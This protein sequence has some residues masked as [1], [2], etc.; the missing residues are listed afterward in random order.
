[1]SRCGCVLFA[2]ALLTAGAEARD[3]GTMTGTVFADYYFVVAADDRTGLERRNAF[4]FRRI[5][6]TYDRD[7][8]DRFAARVRLEAR[9]AGF[10]ER[11][12]MTPFVK[13]AYVRWRRAVAGA[14]L[15]VGE[16]ATPTWRASE[17]LWGYRSVE[18]TILDLNGL[19]SS[20]D[21]G[22]GLRGRAVG[23]GYH[24]MVANGPGQRPEN[25][26]GKKLYAAVRFEPGRGGLFELYGDLDMRPGGRDHLVAKLLIGL[27]RGRLRIGVEPFLRVR[28]L[29]EDERLTGL[30]V[31]GSAAVH[32]AGWAFARLDALEEG[33][34]SDRL[35]I[36]GF[37]WEAAAGVHLQPN[38][39]LQLPDGSDPILQVRATCFLRF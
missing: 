13:H 26:N 22:L 4:Q 36:A 19:G 30:S 21:I 28:R 33:G 37:D 12:R 24:L 20:S 34:R 11:S 31:F 16:S 23:L 29:A 14:D 18:K 38:V 2:G 3:R 27:S 8:S 35:V 5:Y 7:L 6:L 1:M 17:T 9:D 10:G 25:D 15:Y 39:H 32:P